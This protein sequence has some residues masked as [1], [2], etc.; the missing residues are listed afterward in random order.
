MPHYHNKLEEGDTENEKKHKANKK[1]HKDTDARW[2]KK[3][4]EKHFGYK[5]HVKTDAKSKFI[6]KGVTTNAADHDSKPTKELVDDSD[7]GQELHADS[8]YIGKGV[9][10]IMRKHH[11]KDRTLQHNSDGICL[12]DF[13]MFGGIKKMVK[14]EVPLFLL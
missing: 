4:G 6:K 8:A 5:N 10:K 11:M 3:G 9:K 1:R 2:T 14:L 12:T 7:D 13:G